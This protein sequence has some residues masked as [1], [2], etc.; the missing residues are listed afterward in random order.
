MFGS[1]TRPEA[2]R[3]PLHAFPFGDP[4]MASGAPIVL[5]HGQPGR[6]SVW[7]Q[8]GE[9]LAS[10][11]MHGHAVDRPGYGRTA[12]IASGFADNAAAVIDFLDHHGIERATIVTHS[13]AS[14]IALALANLAPERIDGMVLLAPVGAPESVTFLDHLLAV[15]VVGWSLLRGG[16]RLGSWLLDR[17]RT[18]RFLPAG[19]GDLDP[20]QAKRMA[21]AA[22]STEA[23]RSA[24]VEQRSLVSELAFIRDG[25]ADIDMAT[26]VV[27]GT[28]DRIVSPT[29]A[30]SLADRIDGARVHEVDA[31]HMLPAEAPGAVADAVEQVLSDRRGL[32][33]APSCS[34][35]TDL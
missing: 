16:L 17:D 6:A 27:T 14:G 22:R 21:G 2:H 31:G 30:R 24:A 13:W 28:N 25:I 3:G 29:A 12:G 15:P 9:E 1:A 11:G 4:A 32:V 34:S 18:R 23:R 20:I 19:F 7:R 8:V 33:R 5:L 10:R 35:S 26:V